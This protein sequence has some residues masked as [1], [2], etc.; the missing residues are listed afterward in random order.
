[1]ELAR[2]HDA[3]VLGANIISVLLSKIELQNYFESF[4]L[5]VSPR[6]VFR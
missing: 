4:M 5:L 3:L 6:L 1:V 2:S